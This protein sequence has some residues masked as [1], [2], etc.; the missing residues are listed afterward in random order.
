MVDQAHEKE[1]RARETIQSL[2]LEITNLSKLVEQG[3]GLSIGQ[4]QGVNE[5]LKQKE[6]LQKY[7]LVYITN[8]IMEV[9]REG[10]RDWQS[11][12][13]RVGRNNT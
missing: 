4:E 10:G 2:K 5:L 9:G 12:H 11:H 8:S 1:T 13:V 7:V 6:D 3:A